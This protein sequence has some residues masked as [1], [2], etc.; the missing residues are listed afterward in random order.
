MMAETKKKPVV[1]G[2]VEHAV[3]LRVDFL[4]GGDSS[5][6]GIKAGENGE[7][8]FLSVEQA[9]QLAADLCAV[10]KMLRERGIQ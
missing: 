7:P 8:D 9:E 2:R 3:D 4:G 10:I 6:I 5:P 1:S